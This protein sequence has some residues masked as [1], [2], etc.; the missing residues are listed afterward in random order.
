MHVAYD[1]HGEGD[2]VPLV[3][4][5][6]LG[7][8]R[9][10]WDGQL[11]V[12]SERFRVVR[13]DARGHGASPPVPG[14]ATSV[15]ELAGDVI[16]V[17]DRLGLQRGHLAGVSLGG[18]TA[19]WLAI[20]ASDRVDRL[21]VVCSSACPGNP[22][23][24]RDRAAAVRNGGLDPIAD[25]IVERWVTSSFAAEHPTVVAWLRRG[26]TESDAESYAQC[27]ELLAT[28]D[29]RRDLPRISAS[30]LVIEASHDEALPPPHSGIIA[31]GIPDA[32]LQ[33]VG[34]AAHIPTVEVPDIVAQAL[35]RHLDEGMALDEPPAAFI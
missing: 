1:V 20:H 17:L 16:E 27:C 14:S 33:T 24:W 32:R 5:N 2:G 21:A 19:L 30:T 10:I 4:L 8:D 23:R 3:L 9:R 11:S 26:L 31:A 35:L 34:Q 28:L 15:E 29:L 6:S 25:A 22:E 18:M 12:L 7:T 13:I